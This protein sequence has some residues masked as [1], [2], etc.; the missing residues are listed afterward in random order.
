MNKKILLCGITIL[1]IALFTASVLAYPVNYELTSPDGTHRVAVYHCTSSDCDTIDALVDWDEANPTDFTIPDT[2][3]GTNYFA[4]YSFIEGFV[5]KTI[6]TTVDSS[7][8]YGPWSW[9]VDFTKEDNCYSNIE[10]LT[11]DDTEVAPGE[12]VTIT[13]QVQSV[14]TFNDAVGVIPVGLRNYYY[15]EVYVYLYVDD[16]LQ[17]VIQENIVWS[18]SATT[19]FTY[20]PADY[21]DKNIEIRTRA[22]VDDECTGGTT[23]SRSVTL[24]VNEDPVA[25]NVSAV[26]NED[27][28]AAITLDCIDNDNDVLTYNI[29]TG[30]TNGVLTGTGSVR[31]YTPNPDYNGADQFT[32]TCNDGLV[33]SNT[34]TVSIT[35][36]PVNDAPTASFV[37]V[38]VSPVSVGQMVNFDA[39]ASSDPESDPM[40]YSWDFGNGDT[41]TGM[42]VNYAYTSANNYQVTLTVSDG[43]ANGTAVQSITVVDTLNITDITCF[44]NVVIGN[45]QSCSVTVRGQTGNVMGGADVNIYYQADD[46]LFGSCTTDLITGACELQD[47]QNT[48][49][50]HTVYAT[51]TLA[52]NNPDNDGNP[53]FTYTVYDYRYDITD[54][55]IYND[56]GFTTEDYDFYRGEDMYVQFRVWDTLTSTYVT[57]SIV[58]SAELVSPPGGRADL[59]ALGL[60]GDYNQYSLTPIPATHDF[61]GISQ[62]FTFAF[63]FSDST[64]GQSEIDLTIRNNPPVVT[65]V[66]PDQTVGVGNQVQINLSNYETDIEDSGND[67]TWSVMGSSSFFSTNIVGKILTIMGNVIGVDSFTL[68]LT[69]LDGDFDEQVVNVNVTQPQCSDGIDNDGDGETDYPND[70]GCSDATD[71]DESNNWP[72]VITSTPIT[73]AEA[74]EDYEYDV[75]AYDPDGDTLNYILISAPDDMTIDTLTGLIQWEPD[76]DEDGT[77]DVVVGVT[78][79]VAVTTQSFTISVNSASEEIY[80]RRKIYIDKIRMNGMV[81][82]YVEAAYEKAKNEARGSGEKMIV[83]QHIPFDIEVTELAVRHLDENGKIVTS[84]PR[85]IGHYQT[86]GGDYH[87]SWQMAEVSEKAEKGIYEAAKKITDA[88][89]GKGLFGCELFVK[90]DKVYGNEISPRPHDTGM[91]TFASHQVG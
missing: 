52:P 35:V 16:E 37:Y 59:N 3:S 55:A 27:I 48:L 9:V 1:L 7:T 74:E 12:E 79:G 66:V 17:E 58:T 88:L 84:F 32:Y 26:T 47:T 69:D 34:A 56:P 25:N 77:Y 89:G 64:G 65:P 72:P 61:L 24:G 60:N 68:R 49:G 2:Y 62:V 50:S 20:T 67:L 83:E 76:A 29:V 42:I 87:S 43:T 44:D 23:L 14:F 28:P 36:N 10:V 63:N 75:E 18:E 41:T 13:T 53:T 33:D 80:P 82:D 78:D 90:G 19:V 46:S 31:T 11:L 5:P 8:T 57:T 45:D 4:V 73:T 54:L 70:I 85:P 6:Q 39:S 30:P 71:D 38:P 51:A 81:Y 40:T 22:D 21:G 86:R 15:N 91:V